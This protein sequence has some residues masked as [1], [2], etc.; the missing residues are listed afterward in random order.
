MDG[1]APLC[2]EYPTCNNGQMRMAGYCQHVHKQRDF[3][4]KMAAQM[5]HI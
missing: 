4:A 2:K 5:V 3:Q 1:C